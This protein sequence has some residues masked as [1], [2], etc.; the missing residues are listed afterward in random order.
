MATYSTN[1]FKPGLKLMFDGDPYTIIDNEFVKPGKGN[2]RPF[3][4]R[5]AKIR[6]SL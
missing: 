4:A 2:A 5:T 3:T 1:Q 6:I